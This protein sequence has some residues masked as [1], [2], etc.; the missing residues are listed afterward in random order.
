LNNRKIIGVDVDGILAN[1]GR[2]FVQVVNEVFP[3]KKVLL[4]FEPNS[5]GYDEILTA[6]EMDKAWEFLKT[7]PDF[8]YRLPSYPENVRAL[9]KAQ[10][11]DNLDIYCITSRVE[12][13]GTSALRQTMDWLSV[14]MCGAVSTIVVKFP[15]E[16][17]RLLKAI[18]ACAFV[19][20]KL[21]TAIDIDH[22]SK[23]C[24]S[25]LLDRPWNRVGRPSD[26]KVVSNLDEYLNAVVNT[27]E[28]SR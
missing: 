12:T 5:W 22:H 16:K 25:F 10:A 8:W 28:D 26:L 27:C 21:E 3:E 11:Y 4:D 6:E 24:Q 17:I 18:G 20:D 14:E 9:D 2:G 7:V 13:I 19:D 23:N 1:F 15:S